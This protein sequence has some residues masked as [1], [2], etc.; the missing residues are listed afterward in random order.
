MTAPKCLP[1]V[2]KI[3]IDDV[4]SGG[5]KSD[6]P[7]MLMSTAISRGLY[8]PRCKSMYLHDK[9]HVEILIKYGIIRLHMVK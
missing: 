7:Y 8:H 1:F 3:L 9:F 5:K 6:G 2:G 4:W